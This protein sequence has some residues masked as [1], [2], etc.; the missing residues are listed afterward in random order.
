MRRPLFIISV[1]LICLMQSAYALE[2][3]HLKTMAYRNPIG[4][5]VVEPTFSWVLTSDQRGV[6]QETYS[7]RI[8]TDRNFQDIV[9]QSGTIS[10]QES[11]DVP[12]K[13]FSTSPRTRYYWQV[14]VTDNKGN[15]ATSTENAYFETG[16]GSESGWGEAQWIK[17]G[18]G[19]AD[20]NED[21]TPIT[22]YEVEV[23]FEIKSFAAGLI[24]AASDHNNYYMWQT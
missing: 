2:V 5:D 16:L 13:G 6:V 20:Q 21:G 8:A 15:T 7:I 11:V 22:D 19:A 12:A 4:I 10:S 9:W 18:S 1:F 17:T 14:S 23:S 24:F 3:S